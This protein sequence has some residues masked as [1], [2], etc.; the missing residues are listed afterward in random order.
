MTPLHR[1]RRFER[2]TRPLDPE[3]RAA[4]ARRWAE[5]P[6][7]VRTPAQLM[8]R[9]LTGCEGTHGVFPACD[10]R[11]TPC[12]HSADANRVR[13]DGAHTVAEVDAQMRYLRAVRGPGVHAQLIGGE[14]T[15]LDPDD[16][17]AALEVMLRHERLPMSFSHGDV[18]AEHLRRVALR[19]D[20]SRR[21][22]LLA[23]AVHID[24][25]M[26]GRRAAPRPRSERELHG[27]RSATM[28]M[29]H[30]LRREHGVRHHVAHN[31]TVTPANVGEIADVVSTCR[32]MGYRVFSFQPAAHV[33]HRSRWD[34]DHRE[35]G[36][37]E[38]W[39]E[40]E[41][42]AGVRLPYR[43]LQVGDERCNRTTW[44]AWV[45][46]RYVPAFDDT[47][48]RDL[49]ARDAFLRAFPGNFMFTTRPEMIGRIV[50]IAVRRWRDLPIGVRWVAR[51][52]RRAGGP[53][54]FRHG[55]H[56]TTYVMHRFMD[57][58]DVVPAWAALQR[59]ERLG[60]PRL[61]ESQ[62]RLLACSYA[63]AHPD[64]GEIVP[65]CVQHAVEDPRE[66]AELVR[67]LPRRR[68]AMGEG[69]GTEPTVTGFP[70]HERTEHQHQLH[71]HR[72]RRGPRD[73]PRR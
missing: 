16:H 28:G 38:V 26:R 59:G 6:G 49:A 52:V 46:D 23:F 39:A 1:L 60:D 41:R 65:A 48:A 45:G 43:A 25:T 67:L 32:S 21:F 4:L 71:D 68:R 31:M 55:I 72:R 30:R 42:G 66:N 34:G 63:M 3:V 73:G 13:V 53:T 9:K 50:R 10:L 14:V 5:L 8:G 37:D 64:R 62:E 70:E 11:C 18:D 58:A 56:P 27:V 54:A 19:P 36:A 57:A 47:D 51:F 7:H 2:R 22:D 40:I 12:Y 61:R 29:F 35:L 33:G 69:D 15:L 24:S 44:G 20:G 17:A